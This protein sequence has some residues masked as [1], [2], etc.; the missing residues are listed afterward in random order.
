M[1]D[2]LVDIGPEGD[3]RGGTIV[4]AGTLEEVAQVETSWTGKFLVG[5]LG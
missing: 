5:E 2:H 1:A 3:G 4:C